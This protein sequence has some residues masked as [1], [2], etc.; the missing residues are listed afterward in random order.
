MTSNIGDSIATVEN[1]L[2]PLMYSFSVG[3]P[4]GRHLSLL[5]TYYPY[6]CGFSIYPNVRRQ[7]V[8]NTV[9]LI[10]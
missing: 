5:A 8:C 1:V 2:Y 10:T 3:I 9:Q 6:T 7:V 4:Y